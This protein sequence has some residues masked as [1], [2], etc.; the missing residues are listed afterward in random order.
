MDDTEHL[1][2][3]YAA[4][5]ADFTT[6]RDR[7][8]NE[9]KDSDPGAAARIKK[10]RKPT[11]A[12]WAANQ[13]ASREPDH[14]EALISAGAAI[15][16]ATESGDV[17]RIQKSN[18]ARREN[19]KRLVAAAKEV[20]EEAGLGASV[21]TLERIS[22]TL[23]VGAVEIE[24]SEKLALGVLDQELNASSLDG[25]GSLT[26]EEPAPGARKKA[27]DLG[28]LKNSVHELERSAAQLELEADDR[29]ADARRARRAADE[30]RAAAEEAAARLEAAKGKS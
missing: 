26:V 22:N 29:E 3:I 10:V 11:V 20:L 5:L 15:R 28:E 8:S 6:T 25:L 9:L 27:I 21:S 19:V 1:Q 12:I 16:E 13:L 24:A 30:A 4:P 2:Q 7:V 23:Y 18:K 17:T 14:L